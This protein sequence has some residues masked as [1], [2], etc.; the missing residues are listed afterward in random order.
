MVIRRMTVLYHFRV[1]A[2]R[3]LNPVGAKTEWS[4]DLAKSPDVQTC[5][6]VLLGIGLVLA[7]LSAL[8]FASRE[9]RMKTPEGN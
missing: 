9:F 2:M 1:L 3:W 4:I 7:A 5:V 6:L 8:L